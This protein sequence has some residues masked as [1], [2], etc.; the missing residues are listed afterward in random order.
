MAEF[1]GL[2]RMWDNQQETYE[3]GT[4]AR[5]TDFI[6]QPALSL[7]ASIT[8]AD[9]RPFARKGA[10]LWSDGFFARFAFVA[11]RRNT[12]MR[13]EFTP[14]GERVVPAEL[15]TPLIDYH[16]R[17]GIPQVKIESVLDEKGKP[18]GRQ[19]ID[20]SPLPVTT[21]VWSPETRQA[22]QHYDQA[23]HMLMAQRDESDVD[24]AYIRF[25]EKAI[26]IALLLASMDDCSSIELRHWAR[27]QEIIE[28]WRAD[29]HGLIDQMSANEPSVERT[30]EDHII[31]VLKKNM[32]PMTAREVSIAIRRLSSA[33][34]HTYLSRMTE[35][36]TVK[37][38]PTK[39]TTKYQYIESECRRVDS[40]DV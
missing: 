7:L 8:P 11:P 33:E 30:M 40:V 20:V 16:Q 36:G 18:T 28:R 37:S 6:D 39:K 23:L 35:A 14:E 21:L 12:S 26:R 10:P 15:L 34:A 31:A 27:A 29:L 24:G 2:L 19:S 25:P 9:L 13:Y 1:R 5:G 17:L 32:K 22:Y 38:V 3:Y 4:I